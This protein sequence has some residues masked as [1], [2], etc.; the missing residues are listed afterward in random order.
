MSD[1]FDRR[2]QMLDQ[3]AADE[4]EL[5]E[6]GHAALADV[7]R[8][9]TAPDKL[10]PL[11]DLPWRCAIRMGEGKDPNECPVLPDTATPD[12][13]EQLINDLR[14]YNRMVYVREVDHSIT[15]LDPLID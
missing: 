10:P 12:V 8:E 4:T 5:R 14:T 11:P 2:K 6:S 13:R 1:V 7:V 15:R 9:S 3:L